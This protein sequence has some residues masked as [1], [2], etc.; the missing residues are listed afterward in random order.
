MGLLSQPE[1]STSYS[2]VS[3]GARMWHWVQL[4]KVP[5]LESSGLPVHSTMTQPISF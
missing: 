2:L 3:P 4:G 1:D 5:N